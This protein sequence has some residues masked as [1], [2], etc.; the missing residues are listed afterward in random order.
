MVVSVIA[1]HKVDWDRVNGETRWASSIIGAGFYPPAE[2]ARTGDRHA[3]VPWRNDPHAFSCYVTTMHLPKPDP[4]WVWSY[5]AKAIG[6]VIGGVA[7]WRMAE[8][9]ADTLRTVM[10]KR[11]VRDE[12]SAQDAQ[13]ANRQIPGFNNAQS[14]VYQVKGPEG[15]PAL[16]VA[17]PSIKRVPSATGHD[18]VMDASPCI[19]SRLR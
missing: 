5:S 12:L 8:L 10:A 3:G 7:Y 2:R 4:G 6:E 13:A 17:D 15:G 1:N 11:T 18:W 14:R 9:T 19:A 16:D